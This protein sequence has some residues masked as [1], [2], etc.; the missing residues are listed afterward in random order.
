MSPPPASIVVPTRARLSYLEVAL[1]SL[2]PQ[3]A[4]AGAEVLVI[5]DA[6]A[7]PAARELVERFGARYEP[8]PGPL[9]LNVARNTGV[10]LSEGEL[11]VF[12]DD[13]IR[14]SPGWLAALLGAA[15][16]HPLVDVFTGPLRPRLEGRVPRSCGRE[17]PAITTLDLGAADTDARYAWGAN[18]AI[19]RSAL[20]RVGPFDATLE[21]GGDE[22]EWQERLRAQ[23]P[24]ARVLYVAAAA[25]DHR[26]EGADTRL[27]S[28]SRT[29]QARGRAARRFDARRGVA[30][31][32]RRE[33][34]TLAGCLGH[35]VR[36]RCPAGLTMVAH[37]AG[38][39]RE[40]VGERG[41]PRPAGGDEDFLSGTSGT[42]GGLDAVRR[43]I[44]DRA[45]G[46]WELASGRR[47]RLGLAARRSPPTRRVLVLGVERPEHHMLAQAIRDELASSRHHVE[48]H[49]CAPQE[50]GKFENLNLLLAEHPPGDCDWMLVVDD[51]V[52]LPRGFLDRFLFLCERFSLVLAQPAHR[53]DSHAAW[54]VT[55]RRPG[56]VV[57]ETSFVEIGPVTAFARATFPVLLPFPPLRMGWGLDVHWAAVARER[58]WRCGVVDAVSIRHRVAPAAAAYPR[59]HAVAEAREFLADRPYLSAREAGRVIT[60]HRRW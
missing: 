54:P 34:L 7:S 1:A 2:A 57:H 23:A 24:A 15:R 46:T 9:G 11:V 8:H 21:Y 43:A 55:R 5:D 52:E 27:R 6:G 22:Q 33:L 42:V 59:A 41:R 16:E 18:M 38:R 32:L 37:S 50:R 28:L 31:S 51:D 58:G 17:G 47:L 40:G 4:A 13:D 56:S 29:A 35:V 30:P 20:E 14:A 3:A 12:V 49:T 39:L 53:L 26:R 36:R 45:V 19:R 60:T 25:V 44:G 48:L 10:E